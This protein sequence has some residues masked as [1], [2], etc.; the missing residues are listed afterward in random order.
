MSAH[1][2]MESM[3]DMVA[4]VPHCLTRGFSKSDFSSTEN[5]KSS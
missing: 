1:D 3:A 2:G 5:P 4:G